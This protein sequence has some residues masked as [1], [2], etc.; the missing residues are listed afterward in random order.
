[1]GHGSDKDHRNQR[2]LRNDRPWSQRNQRSVWSAPGKHSR[3]VGAL[4]QPL[5]C[6]MLRVLRLPFQSCTDYLGSM[7]NGEMDRGLR[8]GQQGRRAIVH[9]QTQCPL[10]VSNRWWTLRTPSQRLLCMAA[11]MASRAL[12]WLRVAPC[13]IVDA[14]AS[15]PS[16]CRRRSFFSAWHTAVVRGRG[17][18]WYDMHDASILSVEVPPQ[19]QH[20]RTWNCVHEDG[21]VG[22]TSK[23]SNSVLHCTTSTARPRPDLL[24]SST[25]T[26][27]EWPSTTSRVRHSLCCT[28]QLLH[29]LF[30]GIQVLHV[31]C[32]KFVMDT[33][34][35]GPPYATVIVS[36]NA[37]VQSMWAR[38]E[39]ARMDLRSGE[40]LWL[41]PSRRE[42]E[43]HPL[44]FVAMSLSPLYVVDRMRDVIYT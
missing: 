2:G 16:R 27:L 42:G 14:G 3:L 13:A 24:D 31:H 19:W 20:T 33:V 18:Q 36:G 4:N 17:W 32:R 30:F 11:P 25:A 15:F 5:E 7:R 12:A 29:E 6:H 44:Q 40:S 39:A 8:L 28:F 9:F 35:E 10:C 23:R 26:L 1:M 37:Q 21:V 43:S 22:S 38:M 41:V 34:G